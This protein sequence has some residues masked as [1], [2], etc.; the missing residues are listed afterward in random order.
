MLKNKYRLQP[1]LDV[2]D[3]AKQRAAQLVAARRAQLLKLKPS[4]PDKSRR[5]PT[6]SRNKLWRK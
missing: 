4:L 1:V 5:L 2:R 6:A 3:Q